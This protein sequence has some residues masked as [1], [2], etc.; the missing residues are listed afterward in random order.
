[1][2]LPPTQ[3]Q[4]LINY[5]REQD[6]DALKKMSGRE[7]KVA[8]AIERWEAKPRRRSWPL[9]PRSSSLHVPL[10]AIIQDSIKA[11][12][13]NASFGQDD[14]IECQPLTDA[15]LEI[16]DPE[17]GQILSWTDLSQQLEEY[18]LFEAS[19]AGQVPVRRYLEAMFDE[20]VTTGTAFPKAF[21]DRRVERTISPDGSIL[22]EQEVFNN[23]KI[24]VGGL[25]DHFFPSG[26]DS[27]ENIPWF[28]QRF[29]LR[30]S[31]MV[32]RID[33]HGWDKGEV[34][35]YLRE[36]NLM[37]VVGVEGAEARDVDKQTS[38]LI[39][40]PT[41]LN[42][43]NVEQWIVEKWMR[44]ALD[45]MR[46]VKI[47]VEYPLDDPSFIFRC[48]P[49]PYDHG[50]MPFVTPF[51]Y[52]KRRKRLLGMGAAERLESLDDGI[53]AVVNQIIDAGTVANVPVWSVDET[54]EGI[55][56]FRDLFPGA[57]I[58]RGDD[59][60][61]I[62]P[63]KMGGVGP[64]LFEGYN[65]LR[66][67]SERVGKVTDYN[68]GRESS[69]LG[70]QSTATSTLS[71][72][73]QTGSYYDAIRRN[74]DASANECTQIWLD[75]IVQQKPLDRI[76]Q[77]LGPKRA[78]Y[79]LAALSLPFGQ[80]RKRVAVRIALS[81][82]SSSRELQRQ[83][84]MAKFQILKMY[85]E[86]LMQLA[87]ARI[88]TPWKAPL[89]DAIATSADVE[90]RKL[91]ETFGDRT[92]ADTLPKWIT[93]KAAFDQAAQQQMMM[94][95]LSAIAGAANPQSPANPQPPNGAAHGN[96]SQTPQQ[97]AGGARA[98]IPPSTPA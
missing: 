9:G 92:T 78:Q 87:D 67:I 22:G 20:G 60:N 50:M 12:I 85:Y 57:M 88:M 19:T 14:D 30:P 52:I 70:R 73:Q 80:L 75:L 16:P 4:R 36:N 25:E 47:L 71:L 38:D 2:N 54:V 39:G 18:H 95:Q 98:G 13:L 35:R 62:V 3:K 82:T 33:S 97:P 17:T 48:I 23:F 63:L 10:V 31:E 40:E 26:Y 46:E 83:E 74:L 27:L 8:K 29:L 65:I 1:M 89:V 55:R 53:S 72:L 64:D 94:Q 32:A 43:L 21:W 66:D 90:M 59:H 84:E 34:Y 86:S 49:W 44:F 5:N 93:F 45:G 7:E 11:H 37:G 69:V 77:V 56:D 51:C 24:T 61:A 41:D 6:E 15:K 81:S 68:L 96:P 28:A 58:K 79:L 76:A 91:L 42:Y